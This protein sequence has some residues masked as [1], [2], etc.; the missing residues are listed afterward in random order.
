[1]YTEKNITDFIKKEPILEN[2][3][4]LK[5]VIWQN[6][7][8]K[9]MADMPDFS[10]KKEDMV[11]AEALWER[12]APFFMK[13]FPETKITQGILESPLKE[14]SHMKRL[15]NEEAPKIE[16]RLFLKCDNKLPIAG[17]IKARGGFYEV[18]H[19]AE[20]LAFKAG[21]LKDSDYKAFATPEFK[22]FFNQ[23]KIGVGSTGNLGLSIGIIGA[24]LGF[25]VTVYVSADA[26]P[27]KK[28]LLK[29]KGVKVI[30]FSGDF[31][32][33]ILAGR[34][35]TDADPMAYFV[36]DENSNDLFLGYSVGA[37]RIAKQLKEQNIPVDDQHPLFV[38]SPCGVG[39][40]PG[41][42]AF[43]LKQIYG[44]HVHCFFVEPTHS[45]AVLTGLVTGENSQI[46]VQD[47][48]ID[49]KTEADGLAVGRPS[50]FATSISSHIISGLYTIED[51]T[52]YNLLTKLMDTEDEFL[53]PSA[54]AGLI[55]PQ[56]V[57]KT[58][59][60]K[61]NNL[62]MANATHVVWATGGDLVPEKER[63]EFYERGLSDIL[64]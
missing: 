50:S 8:R 48:G 2:I 45:P 42:T 17:S 27:W 15:L 56:M 43:G 52:L 22:Q 11:A 57:L 64:I 41:G 10:I 18:L 62:N 37:L 9:S 58:D 6:S 29:E 3:I 7:K 44:D 20:N 36:D 33:A 53:E 60:A 19:H 14:L 1:M 59:Y 46:S 34:Q 16:G 32:E 39:G 4:A 51:Q 25:Q 55:G 28:D 31:S 30:E 23:Y 26:K 38:Y 24:A 12:F 61:M 49:N 63:L 13:A 54:T 35:Q 5:P 40:S 21:M 47:L